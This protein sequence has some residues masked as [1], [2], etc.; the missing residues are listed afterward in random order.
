MLVNSFYLFPIP[1]DKAN[2]DKMF[3]KNKVHLKGDI[4]LKNV[5]DL[6]HRTESNNPS[7]FKVITK[8]VVNTM[9]FN[10]NE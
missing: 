8:K 2:T 3:I 1:S 4:L 7:V 9:S 5:F 6:G 10:K